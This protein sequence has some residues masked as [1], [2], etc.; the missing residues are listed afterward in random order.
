GTNVMKTYWNINNSGF[1][2]SSPDTT[3]KTPSSPAVW[4]CIFKVVTIN[5]KVDLDTMYLTTVTTTVQA[6]AG[7]DQHVAFD[8][9]V[10]LKGTG[11]DTVNPNNGIVKFEWKYGNGLWI[12][13]TDGMGVYNPPNIAGPIICSLRVTAMDGQTA[14]DFCIINVI[15]SIEM[16]LIPSKG[17]TFQMGQEYNSKA[18]PV[19]N[20]KFTKNFFMSKTEITQ[21][22]FVSMLNM[23]P[24]PIKNDNYPVYNCNWFDAVYYCNARSKSENRDTVYSYSLIGGT[25]GYQCFMKDVRIDYTKKGYRLPTESEWEFACRAGSSTKFY[26]G[27]AVNGSYLWYRN[28]SQSRPRPVGSK[29][30][31]A[32]G[33]YDMSGNVKEW[34]N[35][36]FDTYTAV[37]KVDPTGP[38]RSNPYL[39]RVVRNGSYYDVADSSSSYS[40]SNLEP[41]KLSTKTGFRVVIEE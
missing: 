12:Q 18:S 41:N 15:S 21:K 22:E 1:V 13:S 17:K 23:N 24:S 3:I 31:N 25:I 16:V 5:L 9:T 34:C 28:N 6:D 37:D 4:M 29:L 7:D 8:S 2:L 10:Q 26:W 38:D 39:R 11:K 19:H 33:L 14:T 36:W 32:F 35:D 27:T 40:R 20:V 30:P